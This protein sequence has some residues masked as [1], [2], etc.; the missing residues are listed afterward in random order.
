[1]ANVSTSSRHQVH[2]NFD[3]AVTAPNSD[4]ITVMPGMLVDICVDAFTSGTEIA[5]QGEYKVAD[6]DGANAWV[7]I[8]SYFVTTAK[9]LQF[10]SARRLRLTMVVDGGGDTFYEMTAGTKV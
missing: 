1:M 5:L 3:D 4:A 10:A 9:V 6:A 7:T 2:G 8:E